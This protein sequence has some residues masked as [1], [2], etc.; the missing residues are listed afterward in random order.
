MAT[1][2][3][4]LT[5]ISNFPSVNLREGASITF[6][7]VAT[8]PKGLSGLPIIAAK[9]DAEGR[10]FQGKVFQW[11]LVSLPDSRTG[12]VR[13][14]LVE[15]IGDCSH[16]GYGN[17]VAATL[18]FS[19]IR[20][21]EVMPASACTAKIT[22]VPYLSFVRVRQRATATSPEI[23]QLARG[24]E[25]LPVRAAASD[26]AGASVDGKLY[27]WLKLQLPGGGE[28]WVR[29]DLVAIQ[30]EC[31]QFGYGTVAAYTLA[32]SLTRA[33]GGTMGSGLFRQP[34]QSGIQTGDFSGDHLG[35][36]IAPDGMPI[37]SGPIAAAVV[38]AHRAMKCTPSMPSCYRRNMTQAERDPIFNDP[39]WGW[40]YGN[41][42]ILRYDH[43][44][45][46]ASTRQRLG[47]LGKAGQHIFAVYAHMREITV[48][49]GPM[50]PNSMIGM[51]GTTGYATGPHLH[52]EL[53]SS[54]NTAAVGPL[55]GWATVA[56]SLDPGILFDAMSF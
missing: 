32:A 19:L 10:S 22:G 49:L 37:S 4:I 14:D 38:R 41:H 53:R 56:P 18:A 30:G 31:G 45:L 50:L 21:D 2:T 51:V 1:G 9:A 44:S 16:I 3:A 34:V 12:W 15:L 48:A 25:G 39:G 24:V 23:A 46:P 42:V 20:A 36:D 13:D 27:Q 43:N 47:Q 29:N 40:G 6:R 35:W 52:L 26:E 11:L 7:I 55:M 28:G 33:S 17:L 54:G 5:G 8:V